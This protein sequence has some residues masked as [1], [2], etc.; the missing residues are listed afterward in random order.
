MKRRL[1]T[2]LEPAALWV[3]RR[4]GYWARVNTLEGAARHSAHATL[5]AS[6]A[7][8]NLRLWVAYEAGRHELLWKLLH[9]GK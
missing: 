7:E 8:L 9:P 1:L 4:S 6:V 2:W 3:L 5:P